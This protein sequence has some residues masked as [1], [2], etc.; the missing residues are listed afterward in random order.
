MVLLCCASV[1]VLVA[2]LFGSVSPRI[3]QFDPATA[4]WHHTETTHFD[5]YY[6]QVGDL[7]LIAGQAERAYAATS[8]DL[9]HEVSAKVPLILLPTRRDLPHTT[10]EAAVIVRASGAPPRDH[11]LLPVEPRHGREKMLKHEL[12]HIFEF[13]R[14][15]QTRDQFMTV[16]SVRL[17]YLDWGGHGPVLLFLTSFDSSAHEFDQFAPSFADRF[18][19]LGLTRRGQGESEKPASGYDTPTLVEDIRAFLD[20]FGIARASIAGYSIAGVEET[21]FA[22]TYPDRVTKLVYLDALGDQKSAYEL[23]TNPRTRYPLPLPQLDMTGP[24]GEIGKGARQADPDYTKVKAP[25]LAFCI[26]G[27]GPFIPPDADAE[28]RQRLITR[29]NLYGRPFEEQ[30]REHFRRDM[31]QGRIVEL[32][33]ITHASVLTNPE[34]QGVLLREM[35]EFLLS[36]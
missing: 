22:G 31:K 21:L 33:G 30:Q 32:R 18:H 19:V 17:H 35:R 29:Y 36:K 9:H 34:S 7:E 2:A 24:L 3:T 27:N 20:A 28:L 4:I 14:H 12:T 6:T 11:L 15:S 23:A 25:A 5:I 10:Q 26:I 13:D 1:P 8:H 16:N